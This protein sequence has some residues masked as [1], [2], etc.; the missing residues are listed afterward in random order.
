M[1]HMIAPKHALSD[2]QPTEDEIQQIQLDRLQRVRNQLIK[3]DLDACVLFDPTHIRYATGSRNMQVYSARNPARYAFIPAEGPV[4]MFEFGGCLHLAETLNTIDEVRAA[5]AISY[6]FCENFL[7][8]ITAQWA[9]EIDNLV[10]KSTGKKSKKIAIESATSAAAFELQKLGYQIFDAQEPLE[11]ARC[12]KVKNELK[13]IRASLRATEQGVRIM[14]S[15]IK[16]GITENELWSHLHQHVIATDGDYVETRLLSSG[17]RTNPWFQECSTRQIE[18]GD[19]VALDTDVVGRYG[20]YADFSRTFI[21]GDQPAT[22]NQKELYKL[23][24][25]QV[26]TNVNI[27]KA[28][29]SFKEYAELAWRI[30]EGYK[31]NRYFALVHGVG[32]TGEYPY[33]VHSDDIDEKGY[34]GIFLPGMTI[35]VESYIGHEDGGEGVKLE[36]QIYIGEDHI[37]L[38]SDYPFDERLMGS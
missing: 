27:L 14:E 33:V 34:D 29:R 9:A 22:N 3:R 19:M 37:E 2:C 12:I 31:G 4:V 28:G 35:C 20:Y 23:A 26:M 13:M 38:L 25:E 16:P 15:K 30:P 10:I 5:K 1:N 7:A 8:D 18:A 6:Y 21:C 11:Q 32:M 24:H 36:E 17:A